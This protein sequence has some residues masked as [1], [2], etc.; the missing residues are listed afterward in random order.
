MKHIAPYF[1]TSLTVKQKIFKESTFKF[2]YFGVLN[3]S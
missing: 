3:P 2:K 1:K